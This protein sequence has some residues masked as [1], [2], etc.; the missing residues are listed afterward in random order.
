MTAR[1]HPV[2]APVPVCAAVISGHAPPSCLVAQE[3]D[4]FL[5]LYP[6]GYHKTDRLGRPIYIQHLGQINMRALQEVTTDERM[7]RFHVQ[8]YE[9]ALRYIFPA[10]SI[11]AG[12][13]V[14]QTLAIMDLKGVGLRHL[15]GEVRAPMAGAGV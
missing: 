8:E 12:C 4:A 13:H 15:S 14:S 5:T 6:Q 7:L 1:F 10:C 9:R 11:A 2:P 3:R